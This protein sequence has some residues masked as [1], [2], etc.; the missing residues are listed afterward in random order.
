MAGRRRTGYATGGRAK[1]N[2]LVGLVGII[3][4]LALIGRCGGSE[5]TSVRLENEA[6]LAAATAAAAMP[7]TSTKYTTTDVR[8]RDDT[9]ADAAALATVPARTAVEVTSC[10]YRSATRCAV[11]WG[12]RRGYLPARYLADWPPAEPQTATASARRSGT[13]GRARRAE[14][15]TPSYAPRL[16]GGNGYYTGPRG[17]CYT[18]SAGGRKRY[19]DRSYCQ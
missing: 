7:A 19:V 17:G 5:S 13:E 3:G 8:L 2:R 16:S 1:S 9:T 12:G 4:F 14:A 6:M 10:A 15:S 18:Y 11:T